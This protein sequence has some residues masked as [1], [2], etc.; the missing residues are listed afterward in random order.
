MRSNHRVD[1]LV[2]NSSHEPILPLSGN[3]VYSQPGQQ[4]ETSQVSLSGSHALAQM[5]RHLGCKWSRRTK[6]SK[7]S[8][9]QKAVFIAF[10]L[11]F[12]TKAQAAGFQSPFGNLLQNL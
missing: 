7:Q 10:L 8:N 4:K 5:L 11:G 1:C 3:I 2:R 12:G 6:K 9:K